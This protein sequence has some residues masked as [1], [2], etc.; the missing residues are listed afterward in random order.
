[1]ADTKLGSQQIDL[2]QVIFGTGTLGNLFVELSNDIKLE[3]SREWFNSSSE[4]VVIDTAGKYGAGLALEVIG[5]NLRTIGADPDN[6]VISNKLGW[7]RVPLTTPEP[8]FEPGA[9]VGLKHDAVQNISYDG[10]LE[11]WEQGE[12]LLGDGYSSQLLSV[13]DPDEYLSAAKDDDDR[14]QRMDDILD[15]YKALGE[16]RDQGKCWGVGVGSK[17]WKAIAQIDENVKLDWVMLANSLTI[18]R[19]PQNLMDFVADLYSRGVT[20]FNS[21]VF[22][23]G[24]MVGGDSFDYRQLDP[25]NGYD[26]KVIAY[27]TKFFALCE[28]HGVKPAAACVEFALSPPGVAAIALSSSKASRVTSNVE[29]ANT[30]L[31]KAFWDDAKSQSLIDADY[32]Y[33]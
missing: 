3:I 5:N 4:K 23:A 7:K 21:A 22:H 32:Q 31:P 15:A 25:A 27:R 8:T 11:C 20:V 10:I 9:W 2:P 28:K 16:L 24:Y 12:E 17:D 13:H 6:I 29:L 30:K 26:A 1:M 19:H 33:L 14:A 18:Y